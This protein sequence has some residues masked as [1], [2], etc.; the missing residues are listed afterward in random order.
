MPR[1]RKQFG[2]GATVS[3]NTR[4]L[5]PSAIILN[6]VPGVAIP[7]NHVTQDLVIVRQEVK[8][9]RRRDQLCFILRHALYV[10]DDGTPLEVYSVRHNCKLVSEGPPELFF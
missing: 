2:V 6:R 3:C 7:I 8:N 1:H 5:H 10:G 9:V 4:R